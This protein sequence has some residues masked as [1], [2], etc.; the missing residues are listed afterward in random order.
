MKAA[1]SILAAVIL[2]APAGAGGFL[3]AAKV[4]PGPSPHPGYHLAESVPIF[5]DVRCIPAPYFLN[6]TLDPLPNPLGAPFL[7]LA[8]AAGAIEAAIASW[9][10]IPTSFVE[11]SLAGTSDNLAP[12]GSFDTVNEVT[13]RTHPQARA[14][15]QSR[16]ITL[17]ADMTLA[18]GTDID[19]DGDSDVA[20]GFA[21][22]ADA[23][24]DGDVELPAG[25]YRAGTVL[26]NDVWFNTA[27][28]RWTVDDDDID[29]V[30]Q[31]AD[32]EGIAAHE[33][34]HSVGLP[35]SPVNMVSPTDSTPA[36]MSSSDTDDPVN[37]LSKR[38]LEKDDVAFA[39]LGYPEGTASSGPA[40]LQEEDVAFDDFYGL[41]SGEVRHGVLG[42]PVAGAGVS[43][44]DRQTGEVAVSTYSG[45]STRFYSDP[46]T[47]D[48]I[49]LPGFQS[50]PDG[51]YVLPVPR[52]T[53][54][55]RIEPLDDFPMPGWAVSYTGWVGYLLGMLD[56]HEEAWNGLGEGAIESA[57]DRA[58][59]IP[60]QPG[61]SIEGIDLTT[62]RVTAIEN[63][64]TWDFVLYADAPP[65]SYYA[66]RIPGEQVLEAAGGKRFGIASVDFFTYVLDNSTLP[67]FAEAMLTTGRALPNGTAEIDLDRPLLHASPF[68]GQENDFSP[69][70]APNPLA[71]GL[72]VDGGL[73]LG[74]IDS[75]F[76]VLRVPTET[77]YPGFN[78]FAPVIGIDG[79]IFG[80]NDVPVHGLSYRSF[81]GQTFFQDEWNYLFRLTLT[82][83]AVGLGPP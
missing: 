57:P 41:I 58:Q 30:R 44:V 14:F 33:L 8:D 35:H 17:A 29:N 15:A 50:V 53:Y 37:E 16:L 48:I 40:A 73:R 36:T 6:T 20:A 3:D 34:G 81:D 64:G 75:L 21:T 24:G 51:R 11:L 31:S 66:V 52:G 68:L 25:F 54:D 83:F 55:V 22:C 7:S 1:S 4:V 65:G 63:F 47:L 76:L 69:L 27:S 71:L 28:V 43:A 61:A 2:A 74:R 82:P 59:P 18:A 10:E 32:L 13:F 9:N 77:P 80:P 62:D 12:L 19:G 79:P 46:V 56:F 49:L 78:G 39:A 5:H 67:R 26:D 60:V 72:R 42:R 23:D 70:Y 38:T 45:S